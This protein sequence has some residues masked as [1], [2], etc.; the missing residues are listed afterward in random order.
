MKIA[1]IDI[2]SNSIKLLIAEASSTRGKRIAVDAI[3]LVPLRREKAVVRLGHETLL[4]GHLSSEAIVRAIRTIGVFKSASQSMGADH[5]FALATASVRE[6]DNAAQFIREVESRTGIRIEVLS[7]IE[8]ARL[9]GLAAS[10]CA[11]AAHRS[12]LNIDIGGGSTELS[13]MKNGMAKS[14]QSIKIGAVRLSEQFLTGDPPKT[15]ELEALRSEIDGAL[16]H[17]VR[18]LKENKW[19]VVTGTSGTIIAIGAALHSMSYS[20]TEADS[21][22]DGLKLLPKLSIDRTQLSKFNRH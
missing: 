8:E 2:G 14:L 12:L 3:S 17:P 9:I 1:A 10:R 16:D 19:E 13:L 6:A 20:D 4:K 22:N 15:R 7:G 5:I 11:H 21:I 18:E